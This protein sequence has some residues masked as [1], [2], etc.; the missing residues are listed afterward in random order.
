MF[1]PGSLVLSSGVER[2]TFTGQEAF[3]MPRMAWLG[4]FV[5][6]LLQAYYLIPVN[7]YLSQ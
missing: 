1:A 7:D 3:G 5:K 6:F 4:P 2:G